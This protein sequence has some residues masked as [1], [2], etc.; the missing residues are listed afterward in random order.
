MPK[1][2]K[3]C[4]SYT[5]TSEREKRREMNQNNQA[6]QANQHRKPLPFPNKGGQHQNNPHFNKNANPFFQ[7]Q[8]Q[9]PNPINQNMGMNQ[10]HHRGSGDSTQQSQHS[11]FSKETAQTHAKTKPTQEHQPGKSEFL[12]KSGPIEEYKEDNRKTRNGNLDAKEGANKKAG[13]QDLSSLEKISKKQCTEQ[14]KVGND[15]KVQSNGTTVDV[16]TNG[17]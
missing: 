16:A 3:D 4:H 8:T 2:E 6:G 10:Q 12:Q 1:I 14:T 15:S 17:K 11:H 7:K 5:I 13:Q 9:A